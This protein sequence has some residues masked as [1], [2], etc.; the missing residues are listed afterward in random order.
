MRAFVG[1]EFSTELKKE[2][3]E[4]Q[5]KL[6]P[7]AKSGKWKHS[8]NFHLTLNFLGEIDEQQAL[9]I[10]TT[11]FELAMKHQSFTL[12]IGKLGTFGSGV[13]NSHLG[14]L[15]LRVLWLG[16]EGQDKALRAL[17]S[18]LEIKL[19]VLGFPKDPRGYN[20]HI[21]L[22]QNIKIKCGIDELERQI[23]PFANKVEVKAIQ[24]FVSEVIE[25]YRVYRPISEHK[26]K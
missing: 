10:N 22:A 11:L 15:P 21:T 6:K 9:E 8:D 12:S 14:V 24:L 13:F 19:E 1:I 7:Y 25:G 5:E 26:L 4:L 18:D 16:I 17:Q 3:N 2:I 23:E 20:P